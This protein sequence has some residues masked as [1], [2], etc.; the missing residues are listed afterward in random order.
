MIANYDGS[1]AC[2]LGRL[3]M[4]GLLENN[5]EK[6]LIGSLTDCLA[7]NEQ[8]YL[9]ALDSVLKDLAP[10]HNAYSLFVKTS[11]GPVLL[12]SVNWPAENSSCLQRVSIVIGA[13]PLEFEFRFDTEL[14]LSD[15]ALLKLRNALLL[16]SVALFQFRKLSMEDSVQSVLKTMLSNVAYIFEEGV[17]DTFFVKLVELVKSHVDISGLSVAVWEQSTGMVSFPLNYENGEVSM[18]DEK[19]PIEVLEGR[20][21]HQALTS[22]E[23]IVQSREENSELITRINR[24]S[25]TPASMMIKPIC[26][27]DKHKGAIVLS[28]DGLDAYS[29]KDI[30]ICQAAADGLGIVFQKKVL[31]SEIY[32][33]ANFDP[34]TGLA[35]RSNLEKILNKMN[36]EDE[37]AA[38][39]YV[40]LDG[41]KLV[42]DTH[43]HDVGD[44]LLKA[45][46]KRF[47][48]DLREYDIGA[49]LGGD[50]FVLVLNKIEKVGDVERI[51]QRI[52]NSFSRPLNI[53]GNKIDIGISM[54]ACIFDSIVDVALALKMADTAM[55]EVKEAGKNHFKIVTD[56]HNLPL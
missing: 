18:L 44:K 51:C 15:K 9:D 21:I 47:L 7:D 31:D 29:L 32:K 6:S 42:N 10:N 45:V 17:M 24:Y 43:G 28:S 12:A 33:L 49:R 46:A 13:A 53:D 30:V 11:S 54:G 37:F 41:F 8:Y 19:M 55:Y 22:G 14:G 2:N 5:V 25:K 26:L 39:V 38:L 34:L 1:I 52:L 56:F 36:L 4:Q 50:E 27:G 3:Y 23:I 20:P 48:H 40:D 16:P 35:N